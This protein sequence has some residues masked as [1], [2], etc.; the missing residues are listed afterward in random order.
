MSQERIAIIGGVRT[1][2]VRAR[3]VFQKMS[4]AKCVRHRRN[5]PMVGFSSFR[6]IPRQRWYTHMS[7]Y[8]V[9]GTTGDYDGRDKELHAAALF[10]GARI[11]R[12]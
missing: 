3:S 5:G 11:S 2:F 4:A 6:S 1:P 12:S 7:H 9:W 10:V 8:D